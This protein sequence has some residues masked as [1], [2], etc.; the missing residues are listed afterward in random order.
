MHHYEI[1]RE[2][3]DEIAGQCSYL[4]QSNEKPGD[5]INH[6]ETQLEF[7]SFEMVQQLTG[8]IMNLSNN[9]RMWIL[10]GHTPEEL[11][12]EE[13]KHL[14]PLPSA[15]FAAEKDD[16]KVIDMKTRTKVGRN[17]LCPCGSG[18]KHKKCCGK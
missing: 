10:K 7:P 6:L 17:D 9:T 15:P 3:A 13:R 5:I 4:I 14:Q 18:K 8:E 2:E 12:Q 16:V 11:F 1:T